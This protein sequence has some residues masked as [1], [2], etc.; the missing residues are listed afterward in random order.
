MTEGERIEQEGRRLASSPESIAD[1]CKVFVAYAKRRGYDLSQT[2]D[3]ESY[4]D[5]AT[6]R[7]AQDYAA[8]WGAAYG[9]ASARLKHSG[10]EGDDD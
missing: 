1:L 4:I 5:P 6:T 3:R 8:G 7:S 2:P 9:A 10:Q